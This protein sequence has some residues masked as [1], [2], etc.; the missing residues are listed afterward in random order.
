MNMKKVL[1]MLGNYSPNPSAN[2][3][4]VENLAS[5][6]SKNGYYVACLCNKTGNDD[7][8][9]ENGID[10]YCI[11][12][13]F[14]KRISSD[15][16]IES[17]KMIKFISHC[18][19]GINMLNFPINKR[20]IRRIVKKAREIIND[21]CINMIIGVNMPVD[22]VYAASLLKKENKDLFFVSYF[23][24]PLSLACKHS[25]L[26]ARISYKCG[27]KYEK[28]VV[29]NSDLI[30]CQFEHESHLKKEYDDSIL[31]KTKYIGVPLLRDN[32]KCDIV[33]HKR[34]YGVYAGAFWK[35][36][37]SPEYIISVFK[38]IPFIDINLY[39]S[40]GREWVEGLIGDAP[41]I[42]VCDPLPH[43]EMIRV[44]QQSDFLINVGNN[45]ENQSPSKLYEY[46]GL[47]KPIVSTK[48]INSDPSIKVLEKY[49]DFIMLDENSDDIDGNV[50]LVESFLT[51]E[52]K[53]K[54]FDEL[55]SDFYYSTP[56]AFFEIVNN[57]RYNNGEI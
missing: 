50:S 56:N 40:V 15:A 39:V 31:K 49:G 2:G 3:V 28:R 16:R 6:Y 21:K 57:F 27:M 29:E 47:S 46:F 14:D 54:T 34:L 22:M 24:D 38:R 41:N 42:H 55:L 48:C 36:I 7:F 44:M 43:K 18:F 13:P 45:L 1:F 30:L 53:E 37:R 10:V 23:L 32:T 17:K 12:I 20:H 35:G 5:Y 52:R 33:Q 9:T 25:I 51:G 11:D 26:G 19:L 8:F 4:C